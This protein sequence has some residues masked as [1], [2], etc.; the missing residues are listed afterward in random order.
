MHRIIL[1]PAGCATI[2]FV[3]KKKDSSPNPGKV[4]CYL[5]HATVMGT[6][7]PK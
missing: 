7:M 5:M 3:C 2:A 4:Y 1:I 6:P